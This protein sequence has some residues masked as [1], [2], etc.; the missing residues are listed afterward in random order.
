MESM[1][2]CFTGGGTAGHVFP[3]FAVDE[4]LSERLAAAGCRYERFWIGSKMEQERLW[5]KTAGITH[6]SISCGKLRRYFSWRLL[7]DIFLVVAG[8]FQSLVILSRERPDVLFSKGGY[9]SVPPLLA[10]RILHIRTITHESDAI[11]GLATRINARFADKVCIPFSQAAS[12]YPKQVRDKLVVTGVPSRMRRERANAKLGRSFF[13][14]SEQRELVVV[15]GGSQGATQLNSLVRE[16]VD[17]LLKMTDIVHQTGHRDVLAV[18]REGYRTFSFISEHLED[19]LAA[20]TLVISRS[21]ATALA[22]YMEMSVPMILV[23]LGLG[24]SRGDQIENARRLE[25]AGAAIVLDGQTLDDNTFV[26]AV[27]NLL[28]HAIVRERLVARAASLY[29]EDAASR[30]A[31]VIEGI[32]ERSQ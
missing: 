6:V 14:V 17:E 22:D 32:V 1:K 13:G 18:D 26:E 29:I 7:P 21:G 4:R 2:V 15:L 23:P 27:R 9:V 28:S 20:A 11:P 25:S 3:A 16:N 19:L 10:A 5:V 30:I 12:S 31:Q 8:F 24:A